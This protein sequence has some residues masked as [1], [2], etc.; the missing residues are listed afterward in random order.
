VLLEIDKLP[1]FPAIS[2]F[3]VKEVTNL[4]LLEVSA[5]SEVFL[6]PRCPILL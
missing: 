3:K 1:E 6:L 4:H 5:V 2:I